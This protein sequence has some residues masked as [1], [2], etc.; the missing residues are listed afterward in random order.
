[1]FI[2]QLPMKSLPFQSRPGCSFELPHDP[3]AVGFFA[4]GKGDKG[5][6]VKG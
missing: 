1:M 4:D 5:F 3:G 2:A 6:L